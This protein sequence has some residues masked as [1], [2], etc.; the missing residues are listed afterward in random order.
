MA[1][2]KKQRKELKLKLNLAQRRRE[3][4]EARRSRTMMEVK[5]LVKK[6][7]RTNVQYCLNQLKE[8]EKKRD[9]LTQIT[10]EAN[11]LERE[12]GM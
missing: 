2:K 3:M 9:R 4:I 6:H 11:Q 5:R 12:I 1:Q 10:R 8:L 7:G